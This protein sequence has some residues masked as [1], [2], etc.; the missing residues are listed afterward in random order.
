MA[1]TDVL[2]AVHHN[3]G[4]ITLNRP[5]A[6]NSLTHEM[7]TLISEALH[8]WENDDNVHTVVLT[9]AGERGLCAG[10]DVIAI[11]QDAKVGGAQAR[12]FWRDEYLL[13][14]YISHY[15]KPYLALMSGIVMGGGVGISAHANTR[16]VTETS[17]V[18]LPEV[19]I[20]FIPDVGGTYLLSRAPG[21]LGIHAGLTGSAFGAGDAIAL[22][23]ADHYL[24]QAAIP[25]LIDMLNTH[26]AQEA[27]A[28]LS[29]P[30]PPS[31]LLAQQEWIDQCYS[32]ETVL[33]ILSNLSNS[34]VPEAQQVAKLISSKS[35]IA[36][37]VTLQAIRRAKKLDSLEEVLNQEFRISSAALSS[38]DLIEGIR[39][40]L[41]D[42]D[43]NPQ[44][45]PPTVE[46]ITTEL[47]E[48]YF[49]SAGLVD[50]FTER[51]SS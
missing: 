50:V 24:P 10:G 37:S 21:N 12:S 9:G 45:N 28:K 46:H 23:F 18:G 32:A 5:R 7:V 40:Q 8:R 39:A 49:S 11:Q 22:G 20:G 48:S 17:K 6:I 33:E 34:N 43:R 31:P 16:I 15:R 35:P 25:R 27:I 1:E 30:A 14:S 29:E 42:K 41:I 4:M 44:W 13:N 3:I 38:A 2:T 51:S 47:V 26:S 36:V 19:S